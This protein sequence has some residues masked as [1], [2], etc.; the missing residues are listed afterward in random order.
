M[1]PTDPPG[2]GHIAGSI[3]SGCLAAVAYV[4]RPLGGQR[5]LIGTAGYYDVAQ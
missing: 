4:Y 1:M 3:G 5:S 2:D